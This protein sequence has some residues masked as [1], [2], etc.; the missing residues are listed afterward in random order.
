MKRIAK[1]LKC[2]SKFVRTKRG[3]NGWKLGSREA[4][5]GRKRRR[6]NVRKSRK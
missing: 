5:P 6:K 2:S 3:A 4:F 1:G